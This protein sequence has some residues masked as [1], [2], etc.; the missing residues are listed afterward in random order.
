MRSEEKFEKRKKK[1]GRKFRWRYSIECRQRRTDQWT[2]RRGEKEAGPVPGNRR[3]IAGTG[4]FPG[5][6][7]RWKIPKKEI[8]V[9]RKVSKKVGTVFIILRVDARR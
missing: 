1:D 6:G 7:K 4:T 3:Q 8:P 5:D 9:K 2:N